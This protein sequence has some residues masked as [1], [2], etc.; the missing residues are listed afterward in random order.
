MGPA[1]TLLRIAATAAAYT[2]GGWLGLLIVSQQGSVT[3]IWPST[4][5]ALA[6]LIAWGRPALIGI[7]L[8]A[9]LLNLGIHWQLGPLHGVLAAAGTAIGNTIGPAIAWAALR[10]LG[11]DRSLDHLSDVVHLFAAAAFGSLFTA[12]NGL[13]CLVAFKGTATADWPAVWTTWFAG[14]L[15]GFITV[16]PALLGLPRVWERRRTLALP[17]AVAVAVSAVIAFDSWLISLTVTAY[18]TILPLV[19]VGARGGAPAVAAAHFAGTMLLVFGTSAGRG[20]FSAFPAPH[21]ALAAFL[22]S[23]ALV[24]HG[25]GVVSRRWEDLLGASREAERRMRRLVDG[26]QAGAVHV[27]GG[28]IA[29]NPALER[30]IGWT[31]RELPDLDQFFIH[32]F[33]PRAG[34]VRTLYDRDR[35][36]GF[37]QKR[38]LEA[39]HRSGRRLQVEIA[40]HREGG[41][42][43]WVVHDVTERVEAE[44]T[45]R[46]LQDRLLDAIETL[47]AGFVMYDEDQRL[48]ICNSTYRRMYHHSAHAMAPGTTYEQILRAGVANGSHRASGMDADEWVRHHL[49][50]LGRRD[51]SEEQRIDERWI[52]IDDRPT[53][54]GGVVSLRTDLTELKRI[55]A[56]LRSAKDGAEAAVRAKGE[57][58]ATMSHEIR[59]PLN[60]VIG[61][62]QLLKRT[63]LDP[64][65]SDHL[66]TLLLCADNLL[67]LINGVLD[68]TK[69]EAGAMDLESIPVDPRRLADET[70]RMLAP[71]ARDKGI[72]IAWSATDEVPKRISGDPLRLL[73][74]LVNLVG[75]AVKFTAQGRVSL[76]LSVE[77]ERMVLRVED[78]G[79]GM[80]PEVRRRLFS[81]FVQGDSSTTR[82]HGGTGLGLAISRRL[83]ELM[84]GS[85]EVDSGAGIGTTFTISLPFD[86][87]SSGERPVVRELPARFTGRIL[88]VEDDPTNRLVAR[89][90]L[91]ALGLEVELVDSGQAALERLAGDD[92]PHLVFM[93]CQMPGIDGYETTRRLRAAGHRLPVVAMTANALPGDRDQCLAAGMDDY[94]PKPFA[95]ESLQAV[96][97]RWLR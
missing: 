67:H 39:L 7:L 18:L 82:R 56:D 38:T 36:A 54:D 48:V 90:L 13:G 84:G 41:A 45:V 1:T 65:Q 32:V 55:E 24:A 20:P 4:G 15:L 10:G 58:L 97:A 11:F 40:G 17:F 35:A 2:A 9:F 95:P 60:G 87:I 77:S 28:R 51:G 19:W 29:F 33:G 47:D 21:I 74:V 80:E 70:I 73:Q 27:E 93:D 6:A 61:M 89:H 83:V 64:V 43:I 50:R 69:I 31:N 5:V 49:D 79:I 37:P 3:A 52:R 86:H 63:S 14:D 30:M 76:A 23:S 75:N 72:A 88:V 46:R 59:T 44:R 12:T 96:L 81:P 16:A 8:G 42:E 71:R 91:E 34:E 22:A 94:L 78:T 62:A 57:F 66:G 25:A 53:R 92:P 85:I 26:L 68:F